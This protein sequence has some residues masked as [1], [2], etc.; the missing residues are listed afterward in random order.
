M[1]AR[2][3]ALALLVSLATFS[4]FAC[5]SGSVPSIA[6]D[7][8]ISA[9][10]VPSLG[11]AANF[12]ILAGTAVTCT[13]GTV[14]GDVGVYP[15]SAIT[16]TGCTITGAL[17][18]GD[19]AAAQAHN[20]FVL[21]YD[22]FAA[23][24]CDHAST[25]VTVATQTLAPGVYCFSAALTSTDAVLTLDGPANGV[26]IFKVGTAGTGALTGSRFSVILRNGAACSNVYW[27]AAEAVT[28]TDS[29]LV[30]TILAGAATTFTNGTFSGE[31]LAKAGV[32]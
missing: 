26:W 16:N 8:A 32:T 25:A 10:S 6:S 18:P 27:W 3:A 4:P 22:A 9:S 11:A 14:S 31:A 1:I 19:A 23:L 7:Q 5:G 12:A 24:P 2:S 15:G 13:G 20:D 17:H 21:A 28:M 30:G 29:N